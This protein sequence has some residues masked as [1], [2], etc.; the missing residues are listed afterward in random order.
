ML[1]ERALHSIGNLTLVNGRL[2]PAL[3]NGPWATKREL[4]AEHTVLYLNKDLL[5]GY[6]DRDWDETTINER[7]KK[8]AAR[9]KL[10]WPAPDAV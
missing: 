3:S 2:N 9:A 7:G 8:L 1:R 6:A 10:V 5:I 4:L